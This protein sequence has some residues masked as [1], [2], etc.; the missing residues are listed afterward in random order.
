MH[1]RGGF[2]R[3]C[4]WRP[5]WS[6]RQVDCERTRPDAAGRADDESIQRRYPVIVEGR[7]EMPGRIDAEE[8][9]WALSDLH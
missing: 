3:C 5:S 8:G 9:L 1:K 7:A 2:A 4:R 6:M